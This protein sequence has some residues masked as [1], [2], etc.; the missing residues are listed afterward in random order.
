MRSGSHR[1]NILTKEWTRVG[2]GI[3]K[4]QNDGGYLIITEEFSTN[5]LTQEDLNSMKQDLFT[6]IN[7]TR[8]SNG[9]NTLIKDTNIDDASKYLND[10]I[11]K[12][13]AELTNQIFSD[14]MNLFNI[15]GQSEAIGRSYNLLTI[16]IDSLLSE[17]PALTTENWINIGIDIQTDLEGIINALIIINK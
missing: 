12:E 9:L 14:T 17:E 5:K 10:K 7:E 1:E 15:G 11:I 4:T 2:I 8:T 6:K 16:I 3:A 13:N